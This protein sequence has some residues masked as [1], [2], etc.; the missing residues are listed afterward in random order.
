MTNASLARDIVALYP[1]PVIAVARQPTLKHRMV[2]WHSNDAFHEVNLR[3]WR[4]KQVHGDSVLEYREVW[5]RTKPI[6]GQTVHSIR[7]EIKR[8]RC[9]HC[10]PER[11]K[12][13]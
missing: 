4:H 13:T 12:T 1:H 8:A 9:T 7:D 5:Q 6:D 11:G 2:T 10:H 3:T